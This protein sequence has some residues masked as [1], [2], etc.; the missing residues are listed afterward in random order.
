MLANA[1]REVI[2]ANAYFFPG[3]RLLHAMRNAA[4]RGVR[5]KLI[6]QG[7]P[8]MPIVKLARGCCITIWSKAAFR[9]T[10]IAVDRYMAKS[11]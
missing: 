1:K 3:Y 8:D 4:R 2:I 7:E 5:V 11:R 10:N 9:S 6:V